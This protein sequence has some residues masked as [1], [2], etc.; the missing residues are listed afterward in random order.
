MTM[1]LQFLS[2]FEEGYYF[3]WM[4]DSPEQ[5]D[6]FLKE[7]DEVYKRMYDPIIATLKRYSLLR[8]QDE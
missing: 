6:D 8:N 1:E 2:P 7:F 3:L 5:K 4:L